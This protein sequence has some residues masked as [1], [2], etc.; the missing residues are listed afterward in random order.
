[1]DHWSEAFNPCYVPK[2]ISG[3]CCIL[4]FIMVV[5]TIALGVGLSQGY[6]DS[7][8]MTP[9]DY[10]FLIF[11]YGFIGFS[12]LFVLVAIGRLAWFLATRRRFDR[13]PQV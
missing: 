13:V 9:S 10:A 5:G 12:A 1:M 6:V 3:L 4:C 11:A 7:E 8:E 2:A